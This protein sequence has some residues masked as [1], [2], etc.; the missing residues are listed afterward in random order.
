MPEQVV[1]DTA[2]QCITVVEATRYERLDWTSK[3]LTHDRKRQL[4]I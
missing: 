2:K 3:P 4:A 1:R